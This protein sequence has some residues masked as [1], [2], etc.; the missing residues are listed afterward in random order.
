M[1]EVRYAPGTLRVVVAGRGVAV[2]GEGTTD[3]ATLAI[4]DRLAAGEGFGAV[5]DVLAAGGSLSAL[6]AF[7]VV[8]DEDDVWRVSA[9]GDLSASVTTSSGTETVD[10][11]TASTW[12]ER[13]IRDVSRLEIGDAGSTILPITDGVV[14]ASAVVVSASACDRESPAAAVPAHPAPVDSYRP[15]EP[16]QP[17]SVDEVLDVAHEPADD[18]PEPQMPVVEPEPSASEP[19]LPPA[20]PELPVGEEGMLIDSIPPF[21]RGDALPVRTAPVVAKKPTAS[22]PAV[23]AA[24]LDDVEA[25]TVIGRGDRDGV[26]DPAPALP[27][28][29]GAPAP[30]DHDGE[31]LS[32]E[33]ARRLRAGGGLPVPPPAPAVPPV[34]PPPPTGPIG[35]LRLSTGQVV[36]LDRTVIIG[37]RPKSARAS[38]A[39]LPH[40]IGV[41][42]PQQDI[43]RNHVEVR[44]EGD[45]IL[46]V[47]LQTTNGTT[48]R[49]Q[50]SAP[51]RLH[52]GEA[53]MLVPG[54]V[55]D[56]GDGVTVLVEALS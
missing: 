48:L 32:L 12:S 36:P 38:G 40:L 51:T 56:L 4:R 10:G 22:A 29:A 19:E 16:V 20:A 35:R 46:A 43:S 23:P 7:V 41:D 31:T 39:D 17:H 30:G 47:D 53:T 14:L 34:P 26:A 54:D 2:L 50:G 33:E 5:V 55:L 15:V 42:S 49:R 6:P 9:R 3:A 18:A 28:D 11:T 44:A 25:T 27:T 1:T 8:V 13:S 24:P 37:R 21:I 52:P 45:S